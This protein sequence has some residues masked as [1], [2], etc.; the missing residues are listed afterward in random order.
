MVVRALSDHWVYQQKWHNWGRKAH[1]R[2]SDGSEGRNLADISL[3]PTSPSGP[4]LVSELRG[5]LTDLT[6]EVKTYSFC[7]T[8]EEL[9]PIVVDPPDTVQYA[10][11]SSS[12]PTKP[13]FPS[14]SSRED[15]GAGQDGMEGERVLQS[16]NS[17]D[18]ELDSDTFDSKL[19]IHEED[20]FVSGLC[21]AFDNTMQKLR[22][23]EQRSHSLP[24]VHSLGHEIIDTSCV[25]TT[26][27]E[28]TSTSVSMASTLGDSTS[29]L[30][31]PT[32]INRVSTPERLA[33]S[34]VSCEN[35]HDSG[36][37]KHSYS[38]TSSVT[39]LPSSFKMLAE[40]G[41]PAVA[42]SMAPKRWSGPGNYAIGGYESGSDIGEMDGERRTRLSPVADGWMSQ[43]YAHPPSKRSP[44]VGSPVQDVEPVTIRRRKKRTSSGHG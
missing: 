14:S 34:A 22:S 19:D 26:T 30:D 1:R 6:R 3:L 36:H 4:L 15:G 7:P 10:T 44:D 39:T 29:A 37:Q 31:E 41:L 23:T 18:S 28:N 9:P 27:D 24:N 21:T 20:S 2:H 35:G 33:R 38:R 12:S 42:G 5:S 43:S 16:G 17:M 40:G 13:Y 32:A 25:S 8:E 11:P